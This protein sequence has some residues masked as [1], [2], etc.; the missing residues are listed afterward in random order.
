VSTDTA[1]ITVTT[2]DG[3]HTATC[4]VTVSKSGNNGNN[5]TAVATQTT[6]TLQIYPNPVTNGQLI[7][8]NGQWNAGYKVEIYNL[9]GALVMTVGAGFA[10]PS[11]INIS[12]LPAGVYI[13]KAG[14]R[15]AKVVKQ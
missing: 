10:R 6:G 1:T 11:I 13:I 3:N 5:T 12:H 15:A 8:D 4:R 7:M 9:Q 2:Q 14:G